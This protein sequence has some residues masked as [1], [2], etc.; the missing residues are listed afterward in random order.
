MWYS[1]VCARNSLWEFSQNETWLKYTSK[2]VLYKPDP[3]IGSKKYCIR[4]L[5]LSDTWF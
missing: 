3:E 2:R 5:S 4:K 1:T